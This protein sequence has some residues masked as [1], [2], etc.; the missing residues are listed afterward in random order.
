MTHP[1][2][3]LSFFLLTGPTDL[4]SSK[5]GTWVRKKDKVSGGLAD[6][7]TTFFLAD[8]PQKVIKESCGDS[9]K[10]QKKQKKKKVVFFSGRDS[11]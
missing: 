4:H 11:R 6:S 9:P 3:Y 5:T 1:S 7:L 2:L 10:E 8:D